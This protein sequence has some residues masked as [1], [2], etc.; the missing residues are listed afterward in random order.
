MA[1]INQTDVKF[2]V[3]NQEAVQALDE[4][5]AR[6]AKLQEAWLQAANSGDKA[7]RDKSQTRLNA[8]TRE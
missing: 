8:T 5:R 1:E 3:N 6:L 2:S 7:L 4:V